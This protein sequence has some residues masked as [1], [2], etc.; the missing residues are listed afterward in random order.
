[1]F[2]LVLISTMLLGDIVWLLRCILRLKRTNIAWQIAIGAFTAAQTAGL[3]LATFLRSWDHGLHFLL[4]TPVLACIYLWHF[5]F[6]LPMMLVRVAVLIAKPAARVIRHIA[7]MKRPPPDGP[8][9]PM[10]RRD[11][12]RVA[13][14]AAPA[15]CTL[16]VTGFSV[17]QLRHFRIRKMD[18]PIPNLPPALDGLTIAHITDLHVGQF[19]HGSILE[20]IVEAT[21][22][23]RADLIVGTGDLI[24]FD[25]KDLPAG[26]SVM[27]RLRA[28]HGVFMCEGNHDLFMSAL[29]FR[30]STR[31]A[32][33]RLLVNEN[34]VV[35]IRGT[36]VQLL[37]LPWGAGA[38]HP[39][40]EGNH[41]DAAIAN[42]MREL[43]PQRQPGAFAILLAHHPHAF[44]Y[45]EDLPLTF[46]GHTHGGQLMATGELG[47]GPMIYRYW[48]GLY[49]KA[50][51]TLIVSNGV[52]N[53][54]PLRTAAPAE[55]I[56]LTLR[57]A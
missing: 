28:A 57:R 31:A 35:S 14:C 29:Q 16:G 25:L 27:T 49:R 30:Q 52:G 33:M 26:L 55:I 51:R 45:A 7:G 19:T 8:A 53:W 17:A 54:F 1:M 6:I 24:N 3:V 47:C 43:L 4:T 38:G 34:A 41:G 9:S 23:L 56:H 42:A 18:A 32:G 46:A 2:I 44:D 40:A 15:L 10:T 36:P 21:N 39:H 37:G 12:L 50:A 13:G 22:R 5:L 11:F 20:E 48:S